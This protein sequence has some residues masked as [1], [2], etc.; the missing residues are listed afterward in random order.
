[1]LILGTP[2]LPDFFLD[3]FLT[4]GSATSGQK[5]AAPASPSADGSKSGVEQVFD[6]IKAI[7]NEEIVKKVNAVY[8]F[9]VKGDGEGTWFLDLKNGAGSAGRGE[10]PVPADATLIMDGKDF[11]KMFRGAFLLDSFR[12]FKLYL[13]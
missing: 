5:E 7:S 2:L 10:P 11:V 3:E 12:Y 4:E 8:A 9:Q 6:A 1:M 13:S